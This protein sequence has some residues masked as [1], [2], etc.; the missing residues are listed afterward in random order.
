M[1]TYTHTHT[2]TTKTHTHLRPFR[3]N[4]LLHTPVTCSD[5]LADL[6]INKIPKFKIVAHLNFQKQSRSLTAMMMMIRRKRRNFSF[7]PTKDKNDYTF[8]FNAVLKSIYPSSPLFFAK[9]PVQFSL[10][11][12]RLLYEK[13]T[14]PC[15]A[16]AI[17]LPLCYAG[18]KIH[19]PPFK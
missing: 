3:H 8:I 2:N 1:H 13:P 6:H 18:E 19:G 10:P 17:D 7:R 9:T 15:M 4:T 16:C 11:S 14:L 5:T 12:F